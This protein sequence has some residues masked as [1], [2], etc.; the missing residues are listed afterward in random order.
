MGV[1]TEWHDWADRWAD[2]KVTHVLFCVIIYGKVISF[3]DLV[4]LDWR[5]A[6]LRNEVFNSSARSSIRSYREWLFH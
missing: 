3:A 1:A 5:L 6:E 4:I 2:L